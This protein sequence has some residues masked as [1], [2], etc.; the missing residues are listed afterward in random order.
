MTA[1]NE[2]AK[3][4]GAYLNNKLKL[5]L[6]AL[7]VDPKSSIGEALADM[8]VAGASAMVEARRKFLDPK[9]KQSDAGISEKQSGDDR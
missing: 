5:R 9:E 2:L 1:P 8:F 4:I 3:G 6:E 7:G